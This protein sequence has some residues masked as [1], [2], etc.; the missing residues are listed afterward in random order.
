M[1]TKAQRL[2][3]V[4][5]HRGSSIMFTRELEAE[6]GSVPTQLVIDRET[7]LEFGEPT[8]IT[9]TIQPGDLLNNEVSED[10]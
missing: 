9:I 8:E 4:M 10:T 3:D 2:L 6:D 7:W 1:I 5:I